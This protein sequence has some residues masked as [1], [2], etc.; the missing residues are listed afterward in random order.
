VVKG[1]I[2]RD[3]MNPNVIT[4][5]AEMAVQELADLFTEKMISGAPVVDGDGKLV[6]V[7]SL[8]DIV[9]SDG[10]G[11]AI[12]SDALKSEYFLSGWEDRVD[13]AEFEDLRIEEDSGLMA[14]DIM[15]PTIF[16]VPTAM[17]IGEM[18][19]AMIRGR[20]HRLIV[21]QGKKV[22]GIVTTLDM[23]EAIRTHTEDGAFKD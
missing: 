18:A 16:C 15:T 8:A 7:V 4:V 20:I 3:I 11:R 22:V 1:L 13:E 23:L 14:R 19:D 17:P 12:E 6:G 21:T 5:P 10:R 9:R 2:A